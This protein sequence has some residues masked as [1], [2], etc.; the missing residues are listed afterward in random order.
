[1]AQQLQSRPIPRRIGGELARSWWVALTLLPLGIGTWAAFLY[2]G[3]RKGVRAW[4]LAS[5]VYAA[6]LVVGWAYI[7]THHGERGG[8]HSM[9]ALLL[10]GIWV[11]G[12]A[13][14]LAIRPRVVGLPQT[15][16]ERAD[17]AARERLASRRSARSIAQTD[18]EFAREL[19]IGRPDLPGA[20]DRGL[21]DI[22]NASAA[23]IS[24]V[25][26]IDDELAAAIVAARERVDG[27]SSVEDMG[28]L[29]DLPA[30]T[31]ERLGRYCICLPR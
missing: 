10:I 24:G 16:R 13:H 23:A 30:R 6:L 28:A 31:V 18:P 25:P 8:L 27:F 11:G 26:G 4:L 9:A 1:M 12:F 20:D 22:N 7:A 19:G 3:L 14:A 15:R 5:A 29:L 17:A 2:A 21:V